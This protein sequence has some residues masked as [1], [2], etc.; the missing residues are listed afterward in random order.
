MNGEA[1][2]EER[3][4]GAKGKNR[5][6]AAI[7]GAVLLIAAAIVLCALFSGR[8]Q[9]VDAAPGDG[10]VVALDDFYHAEDGTWKMET[11]IHL[12]KEQKYVS[13]DVELGHFLVYTAS[14]GEV[15]RISQAE[16]RW[17]LLEVMEG[18]KA[19]ASGW[20]DAEDHRAE[21]Q[22]D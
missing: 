7:I 4:K 8:T 2:T 3:G 1:S 6:L 10:E 14:P 16:G 5:A 19:K 17:K 12:L 18:G 20:A 9:D 21:L 11:T 13:S 15:V 22:A